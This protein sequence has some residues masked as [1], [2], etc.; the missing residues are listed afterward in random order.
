MS[1]MGYLMG[2]IMLLGGVA[3]C[4]MGVDQRIGGWAVAGA[5]LISSTWLGFFV[6]RSGKPND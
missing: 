5:I 6:L 3:L 1:T 2:L 4:L